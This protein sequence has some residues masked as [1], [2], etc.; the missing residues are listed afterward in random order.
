VT[1]KSPIS[2]ETAQHVPEPVSALAVTQQLGTF[3][4]LYEASKS[5]THITR[6]VVLTL[7][8]LVGLIG[9]VLLITGVFTGSMVSI[10]RFI[11]F[12][13]I[14]P[15][16][17]IIYSIAGIFRRNHKAYAYTNGLVYSAGSKLS[18][19]IWS[20][21]QEIR[22]QTF[23]RNDGQKVELSSF[24]NNV[25]ELM[26]IAEGEVTGYL[27]PQAMQRYTNGNDL[28]F[29]SFTINRKGISR[30]GQT[31]PWQKISTVGYVTKRANTQYSSIRY[32][33]VTTKDGSVWTNAL[34]M[35]VPN[36]QLL[37]QVARNILQSTQE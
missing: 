9:L 24:I 20:Q 28:L 5:S 27:L 12:S 37:F 25:E 35:G 21:V 6:L 33:G 4:K 19:V 8:V 29:G 16:F 3:A 36:V 1:Q 22:H 13:L 15:L 7:W 34:A 10:S 31:L 30:D 11:V 18:A 2:S 26:Q 14:I 32:V 23:Q 17:F